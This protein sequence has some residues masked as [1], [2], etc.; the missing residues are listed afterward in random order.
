MTHLR[1]S[2]VPFRGD[3]TTRLADGLALR[4]R[5]RG[6]ARLG[7][8]LGGPAGL[9]ADL[10]DGHAEADGDGGQDAVHDLEADGVVLPGHDDDAA[11]PDVERP[12]GGGD[13]DAA[14]AAGHGSLPWGRQVNP[15]SFSRAVRAA[16]TAAGE[17]AVMGRRSSGLGIFPVAWSTPLITA[18]LGSA[19]RRFTSG[20]SASE[21]AR[22]SSSLPARPH[23]IMAT[24]RSVA[25]LAEA[26]MVPAPPMS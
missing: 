21:A 3:G 8:H 12:D 25:M 16:S 22:P 5:R 10:A 13:E 14:L 7:L 17:A 6:R 20:S 15:P 26:A 24:N 23:S 18:G 1:V 19:T 9:P 4:G 11:D 2:N